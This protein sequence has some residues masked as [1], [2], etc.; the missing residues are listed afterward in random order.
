MSTFILF[1]LLINCQIEVGTLAV[2]ILDVDFALLHMVEIEPLGI[3]GGDKH[4]TRFIMPFI[5]KE[6]NIL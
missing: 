4:A 6:A 1:A 2:E 5:T 3:G